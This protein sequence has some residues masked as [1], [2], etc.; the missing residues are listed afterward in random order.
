L[1]LL[2]QQNHQL[3]FCHPPM[4]QHL[5]LCLLPPL[6]LQW[7]RNQHLRRSLLTRRLSS[8]RPNPRLPWKGSRESQ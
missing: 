6:M 3:R 1:I 8:A 7:R 5:L 2:R 4:R